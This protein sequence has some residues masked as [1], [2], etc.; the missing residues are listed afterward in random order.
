M[1]CR[2]AHCSFCCPADEQPGPAA[3]HS[4]QPGP[5]KLPAPIP[6]RWPSRGV[7][8]ASPRAVPKPA[9]STTTLSSPAPGAWWWVGWGKGQPVA[10]LEFTVCAACIVLATLHDLN[11]LYAS[12]HGVVTTPPSSLKQ[13]RDKYEGA[14]C[15]KLFPWVPTALDK[16]YVNAR[17]SAAASKKTVEEGIQEI[18]DVRWGTYAPGKDIVSLKYEPSLGYVNMSIYHVRGGGGVGGRVGGALVR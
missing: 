16:F 17:A 6:T 18:L 8:L 15:S 10:R 14:Q 11:L 5:A 1:D 13:A 4:N 12:T 2:D 3:P 9:S 7:A